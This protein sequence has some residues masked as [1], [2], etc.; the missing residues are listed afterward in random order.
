[1]ST[2]LPEDVDR[3][4]AAELVPQ[5][6]A[7]PTRRRTRTAQAGPVPADPLAAE[8]RA[9]LLAALRTTAPRRTAA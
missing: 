7:P 4:L 6:P 8:H 3:R 2:H 1:M 5:C 9:Q